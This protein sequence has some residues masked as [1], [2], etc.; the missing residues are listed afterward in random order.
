MEG[1]DSLSYMNLIVSLER[2]FKIKFTTGE[3][4]KLKNVG[5]LV[6]LIQSKTA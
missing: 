2:K 1:W 3:V 4:S 5:E 6:S